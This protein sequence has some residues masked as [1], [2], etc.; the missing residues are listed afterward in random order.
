MYGGCTALSPGTAGTGVCSPAQLL[1]PHRLPTSHTGRGVDLSLTAVHA[2][3]WKL[4][5]HLE[6]TSREATSVI[7][8]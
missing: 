7:A 8:A 3:G 1:L 5:P 2:I 4:H 6:A